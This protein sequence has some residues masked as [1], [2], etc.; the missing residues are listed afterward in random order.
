MRF[1]GILPL[2]LFLFAVPALVPVIERFW[3][4]ATVWWSAG[5]VGLLGAAT[6]ALWLVYRKQLTQAGM[7]G[8]TPM[9]IPGPPP[10]NVPTPQPR[11]TMRSWL[12]G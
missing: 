6:S 11:S 9:Q 2:A 5:L 3:P 4:T 10:D 7:P 1:P 12:L 8:P